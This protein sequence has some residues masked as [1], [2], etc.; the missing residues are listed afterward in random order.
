MKI[1]WKGKGK[2]EKGI[3]TKTGK[4]IVEI[5]PKYYRLAEV[6][7][8]IGDYSKA[9]KKLGWEPKTKFKELVRLMVDA[10]LKK[11]EK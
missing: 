7:V 3:D 11:E 8:L 6:D 2:Q 4:V 1:V 5:D 10:D 9:R